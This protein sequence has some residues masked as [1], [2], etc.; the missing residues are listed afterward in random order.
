MN[1]GDLE[2][3]EGD[4]KVRDTPQYPALEEPMHYQYTQ[5]IVIITFGGFLKSS[6]RLFNT[7]E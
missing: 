5:A 3:L 4:S 6:I 7:A 1:P 2:S